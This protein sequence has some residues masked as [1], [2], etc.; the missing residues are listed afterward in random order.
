MDSVKNKMLNRRGFLKATAA[1][2][3]AAA[4]TTVATS[5]PAMAAG[6]SQ[7]ADM[8]HRSKIW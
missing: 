2:S 5:T 8:T 1:L 4:A 3:T 6:H 7:V